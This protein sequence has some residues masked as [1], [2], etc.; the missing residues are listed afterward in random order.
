MYK[1]YHL[2]T[3]LANGFINKMKFFQLFKERSQTD[4][5]LCDTNFHVSYLQQKLEAVNSQ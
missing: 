5:N 4:N 2:K 1:S 3:K